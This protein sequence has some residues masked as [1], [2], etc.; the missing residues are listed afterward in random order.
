MTP[1]TED[2]S[3]RNPFTGV[4]GPRPE[5]L[6]RC[7]HCGL[8]L[9]S[10]PTYI[11]LGIEMESPRGRIALIRAVQDERTAVTPELESHLDLCLQCRAC[12]AVC[13][14]GVPFGRIMEDARAALQPMRAGRNAT[15]LQT[16]LLRQVVGR[17]RVLGFA[18][19]LA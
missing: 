18:I 12:E 3:V 6:S 5:D 7:V 15:R 13:P 17:K 14:S 2:L 8:C 9:N 11:E 10:C 19:G 4:G 16:F 1:L